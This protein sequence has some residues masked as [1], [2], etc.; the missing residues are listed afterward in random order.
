M[1]VINGN[2]S[3]KSAKRNGQQCN[4]LT[5]LSAFVTSGASANNDLSY[6]TP[7]TGVFEDMLDR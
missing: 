6:P 2:Q 3:A 4:A 5:C 1:T 7:F